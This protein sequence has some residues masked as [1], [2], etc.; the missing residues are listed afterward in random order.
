MIKKRYFSMGEVAP[1]FN[2]KPP[3]GYAMT[4]AFTD[5]YGKGYVGSTTKSLRGR[6][7]DGYRSNPDLQIALNT[8]GWDSMHPQILNSC[9]PLRW[10][11]FAEKMDTVRRN[12][13][14]PN[15]YNVTPGGVSD[16]AKNQSKPVLKLDPVTGDAL[17][18]FPSGIAAARAI[19]LHDDAVCKV[20]RGECKSSGGYH[21]REPTQEEL[22]FWQHK[23]Y[24]ELYGLPTTENLVSFS[25]RADGWSANYR[26]PETGE[27]TSVPCNRCP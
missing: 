12:T 13:L 3:E 4:Y 17:E 8:Y 16:W 1:E 14:T 24:L 18:L 27:F 26:N 5:P 19:G 20:I 2:K 25:L 11:D 22:T 21:W 9:V 7:N 23:Q 15:G 10:R 6:V